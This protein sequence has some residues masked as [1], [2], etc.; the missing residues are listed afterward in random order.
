M[1][2]GQIMEFDTP[3]NLIQKQGSMYRGNVGIYYDL[4]K[5]L[6]LYSV[7]RDVHTKRHIQATGGCRTGSRPT[8]VGFR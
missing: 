7:P 3:L 4:L 1:D 6:Y 5:L 2:H 8:L